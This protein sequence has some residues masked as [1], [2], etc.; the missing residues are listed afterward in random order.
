MLYVE[1]SLNLHTSS[2]LYKKMFRQLLFPYGYKLHKS[3][4]YKEIN[5]EQ[6]FFITAK[7]ERYA[8]YYT[9][10]LDMLPYCMDIEKE[11]EIYRQKKY[12]ICMYQSGND[13]IKINL[14]NLILNN[15]Y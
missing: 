14:L 4:F 9:V 7:E 6:C 1:R 15:A 5:Q 8:P 2:T 13:D 11:I 12:K 10:Y 3:L